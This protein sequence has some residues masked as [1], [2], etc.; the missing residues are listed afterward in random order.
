MGLLL[1]LF[2]E[3]NEIH[4]KIMLIR[5]VKKKNRKERKKKK[6]G[7]P[8]NY[9][10]DPNRVI[11]DC[12]QRHLLDILITYSEE[13]AAGVSSHTANRASRINWPHNEYAKQQHFV[14]PINDVSTI[15]EFLAKCLSEMN[16]QLL[17]HTPWT[18]AITRNLRINMIDK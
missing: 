13:C 1:L 6:N 11:D 7:Y 15:D 14:W 8:M 17:T 10:I 9:Q 12:N 5:Q 18:K 16:H 3:C 2:V 4:Y